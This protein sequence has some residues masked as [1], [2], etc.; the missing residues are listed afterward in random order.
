MRSGILIIG[1]ILAVVGIFLFFYGQGQVQQVEQYGILG[2]WAM[3]LDEDL[4]NQYQ[5]AQVMELFG[6]IFGFVGVILCIAGIVAP[7]PKPQFAN[8]TEGSTQNNGTSKIL[9][10]RYAKGEITKEEYEQMKKDI[11][12]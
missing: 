9:K 10:L 5:V 6:I 2:E 7:C 4:A 3:N 12:G 1:I 8:K 11:E